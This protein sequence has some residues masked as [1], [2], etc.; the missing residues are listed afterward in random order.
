MRSLFILSLLL[1]A[2]VLTLTQHSTSHS[3]PD[4]GSLHYYNKFARDHSSPLNTHIP[5][6]KHYSNERSLR[7]QVY[8]ISDEIKGVERKAGF[9][10]RA[11]KHQ[12]LALKNQAN[13]LENNSEADS[14]VAHQK[15]RAIKEDINHSEKFRELYEERGKVNSGHLGEALEDEKESLGKLVKFDHDRES[16]WAKKETRQQ[17][18]LQGTVAGDLKEEAVEAGLIANVESKIEAL[19]ADLSGVQKE[20]AFAVLALENKKSHLGNEVTRDVK[21][22]AFRRGN[23]EKEEG[24]AAHMD[25]HAEHAHEGVDEHEGEHH[26]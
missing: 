12:L 16:H 6:Q 15:E 14:K 9:K 1:S 3:H 26:M 2:T 13:K 20:A 17:G 25:H 23:E 5:L 24:A 7:N 21:L 18:D 11:L 4:E 8:K 19:K 22:D 10:E